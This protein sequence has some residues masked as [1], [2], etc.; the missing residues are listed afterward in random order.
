MLLQAGLITSLFTLTLFLPAV[1]E[2]LSVVSYGPSPGRVSLTA[3]PKAPS[4]FFAS[5]RLD[6]KGEEH[7]SGQPSTQ[8][9]LNHVYAVLDEE[10]YSAIRSSAFLRERFAAMDTGLPDFPAVTE[11]STS[12][13]IRGKQTYVELMGPQNR[14]GEPVG[15]VGIGLGVDEG[16]DLDEVERVWNDRLGGRV[17]RQEQEWTRTDPPV[18]WHEVVLHPETIAGPTVVV[19]A[20]AYR[21]EFLP[22]LYPERT[23]Q[24]NG[25]RRAD[26]LAPRFDAELMLEDI[27]EVI[28]ALPEDLRAKITL[29]LEAVGYKT[30]ESEG[31]VR[32]QGH[33]WSL[34]LVESTSERTGLVGL[35][36]STTRER[37]GAPILRLGGRSVMCF[38]PGRAGSWAFL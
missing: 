12:L 33:A 1:Q 38:G 35:Q 29:Q 24:E 36:F 6:G 27:T 34:T 3:S 10:S 15:K 13:Y 23:A 14:F 26:F 37:E 19:W 21:P 5:G 32:L 22:W 17:I 7:Q 2:S 31:S 25:V 20:S 8:V 30:V 9:G 16:S 28:L 18:P 11:S 4:L